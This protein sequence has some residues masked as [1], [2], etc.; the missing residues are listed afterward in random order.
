MTWYAVSLL[1]KSSHTQPQDV[2]DALW[3]ESIVL[4]NAVT[5]REAREIA[6]KRAHDS[7]HSYTTQ[8][9][10][11]VSWTFQQVERVFEIDADILVSGTEVFSRF[12]RDSEVHSL[13]TPFDSCDAN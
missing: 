11:S 9:N 5:E 8:G 3:E 4:I 13:L 12:L 2:E 7:E 6:V 10:D 1:F